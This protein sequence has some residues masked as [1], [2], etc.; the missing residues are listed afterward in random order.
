MYKHID[1][2]HEYI[3]LIQRQ[4]AYEV[5]PTDVV[6]L[7][8]IAAIQLETKENDKVIEICEQAMELFD[9]HNT[10]FQLRAR[11]QQRLGMAYL[12]KKELKKAVEIYL[13]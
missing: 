4:E 9:V 11:I 1:S 10:E 7:S 12:N 5:D 2:R 6:H 3:L 13:F 8:N